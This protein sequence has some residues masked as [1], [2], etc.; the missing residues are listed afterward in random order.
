M[1]ATKNTVSLQ[2]NIAFLAIFLFIFK[3]VAW[4]LTHSVAVF[5]DALESTVNVASGLI[6]WYSLWLASQ[7]RD[8]NHPYGHGKA[9]YISAAIEGTMISIAGVLII[10]EAIK[11]LQHP[12]A[13]IQQLD[14]GIV[15]IFITAII[16]Y[17]A[18]AY[19]IKH[20]EK[21]HSVALV[22][23]GKH[24]QTDTYSTLGIIVALILIKYTG[25]VWLDPVI[26]IVF[27]CF[28]LYTGYNVVRQSLAGIMDE[29]DVVL[30]DQMITLLNDHR[31]PQWIDLHN[32]RIIK[33]GD[34][35]HID[36]HATMPWYFTVRQAHQEIEE[37]K[38]MVMESLGGS[39]ELF[40]HI[41]DCIRQSCQICSM[42]DCEVRQIP[43]TKTIEWT[44]E[45]VQKNQ[46]HNS[47]Q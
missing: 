43:H 31:R 14:I 37:M 41:D 36:A 42:Q 10:Y 3:I 28:I 19:A 1:S 23:S 11:N 13:T 32:L 8:S 34:V 5:T 29:A 22:A 12:V 15:L 9:E 6:G 21:K 45:N 35:L 40:V 39:V 7:P 30:I 4:K 17:V 27:A 20:G 46:K 47:L 24:L 16:N 44:R 18:G 33:Y 38:Q 26:A 25:W 2:R